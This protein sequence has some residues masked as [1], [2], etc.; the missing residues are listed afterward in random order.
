MAEKVKEPQVEEAQ[1]VNPWEEELE[2]ILDRAPKSEQNFILASVNGRDFQVPRDGKP[3]KVPRP[4]YEVIQ[5]SRMA[6]LEAQE[7]AENMQGSGE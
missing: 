2:I 6:K 1:E 3:H 4:I 5:A 7:R